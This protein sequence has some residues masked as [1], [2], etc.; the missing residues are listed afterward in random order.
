VR[1]A[2]DE[3]K[4][5]SYGQAAS[6]TRER[7]RM[8]L[9]SILRASA[10]IAVLGMVA[11]IAGMAKEFVMAYWFGTSAAVDALNIAML[12]P[13]FLI[14]VLGSS[15]AAALVPTYVRV[16]ARHGPSAANELIQS[17]SAA[18][19]LFA[20]LVLTLLALG[21]R[22]IVSL[23]A[24]GFDGATLR[25]TES[26]YLLL[27]PV[28]FFGLIT[29]LWGAVLNA[30][31]TFDIPAI[32]PT[33]VA[34]GQSIAIVVAANVWGI[35]AAATGALLG[36][37][38]QVWLLGRALFRRDLNPMPRWKGVSPELRELAGQYLPVLAGSILLAGTTL[39]DQTMAAYLPSGS[40]AALGY[41]NKVVALIVGVTA[42][43]LGTAV[44]PHFS[45]L[46]AEGEWFTLREILRKY[47]LWTTVL[48]VLV[49]VAL[50]ALSEPIVR[51]LFQHGAFSSADAHRVSHIQIFYALQIPFQAVGILYVRLISALRGNRILFWGTA[52]SF[53]LNFALNLA[54]MRR[55]GVSGIALSTSCVYAVACIFLITSC[56][57]L[58][59]RA[60]EATVPAPRR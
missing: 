24:G 25:L 55:Y 33:V 21:M 41:G 11:K 5:G 31:G 37:A 19:G 40:V 56:R 12:L 50:V 7:E 6:A 27:L 43:A 8:P 18:A 46:A 59:H 13:G 48:S 34:F 20:L 4:V 28:V 17:T 32:S 57:I 35:F 16:R 45:K 14:S 3:V 51:L 15:L 36:H 38:V 22:P 29:A 1:N 23:A 9:P 10:T 52:V 39:V 53:P 30:E 54:F 58:L 44:L 60:S 49:T 2:V 42:T 26:L 47:S